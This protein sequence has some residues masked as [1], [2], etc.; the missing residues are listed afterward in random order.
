MK[1]IIEKNQYVNRFCEFR[2]FL[3]E[4]SL[5]QRSYIN[6]CD[7]DCKLQDGI[8][9][10]ITNQRTNILYIGSTEPSIEQRYQEHIISK[11]IF[12]E[13]C[14]A[15]RDIRRYMVLRLYYLAFLPVTKCRI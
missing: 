5:G 11:V 2:L 4:V 10:K 6:F 12:P 13:V 7:V 3:D 1:N 9:Y 8:M 15:I 14:S